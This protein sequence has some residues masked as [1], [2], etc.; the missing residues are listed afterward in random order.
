MSAESLTFVFF[1]KH[2]LHEVR[3]YAGLDY[4]SF[5]LRLHIKDGQHNVTHLF[6]NSQSEAYI[7]KKQTQKHPGE[8]I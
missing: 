4:I 3:I 7:Y 2:N 6:M 8:I 5:N 1:P